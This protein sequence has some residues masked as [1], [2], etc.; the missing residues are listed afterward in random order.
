MDMRNAGCAVRK[1]RFS[2]LTSHLSRTSGF[3]LI[4]L[5]VVIAIIA[6]LAAM[7][8][9]ALAQAREKARTARCTSNLKQ[10]GLAMMMY[11]QD[12]GGYVFVMKDDGTTEWSEALSAQRYLTTSSV[13]VCPSSKAQGVYAYGV[14]YGIRIPDDWSGSIYAFH[15]GGYDFTRLYTI[16]NPS[17]YILLSDSISLGSGQPFWYY[18]Y[19]WLV[20]SIGIY[21]QHNN[22]ANCLF[23]DGHVGAMGKTDLKTL[24]DGMSPDVPWVGYEQDGTTF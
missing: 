11:A 22:R 18:R 3:T 10:I 12:N 14:T 23:A 6:I 15:T 8:L 9:P 21:L 5:L 24:K 13:L 7:L 4:E 19:Q 17:N 1:G 16:A 2:P 20:Y